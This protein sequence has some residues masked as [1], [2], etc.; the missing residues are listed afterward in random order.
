MDIDVEKPQFSELRRS[1]MMNRSL[2]IVFLAFIWGCSGGGS[3][4]GPDGGS[5][6]S[7]A[8]SITIDTTA[9]GSSLNPALLGQ[10]DL[11]GALYHY[12]DDSGLVGAMDQWALG[13][14]Y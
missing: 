8:W 2:L 6:S 9:S 10:Y 7:Q 5:G 1:C 4:G 11:S 13:D 3:P 14:G 12:A